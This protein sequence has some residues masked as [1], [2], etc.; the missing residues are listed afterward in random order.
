LADPP[1]IAEAT[2]LPCGQFVDHPDP[3]FSGSVKVLGKVAF[4][5]SPLGLNPVAVAPGNWYWFKQGLLVRA[6]T[7]FSIAVPKK[8]RGRMAIGWGEPPKPS[9]HVAVDRCKS[10]GLGKWIAYPGGYWV[11]RPACA[12]LV[13]TAGEE[14]RVVHVGL[15]A[16]CPARGLR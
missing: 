10:L 11:D 6:G 7:E 13:V 16:T 1:R 9:A 8:W 3:P 12:P 4:P 15:G 5:A 2:P 14:R